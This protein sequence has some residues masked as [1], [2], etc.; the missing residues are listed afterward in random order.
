MVI[1]P[2]HPT[3]QASQNTSTSSH[4]GSEGPCCLP[5]TQLVALLPLHP[6]GWCSILLPV[7]APGPSL[8]ETG[9]PRKSEPHLVPEQ[10]PSRQPAL[11]PSFLA[12]PCSELTRYIRHS[13]YFLGEQLPLRGAPFTLALLS[14]QL[15][16]QGRS[17]HERTDPVQGRGCRYSCLRA[18]LPL[19]SENSGICMKD[20]QAQM[21]RMWNL[22]WFGAE[23]QKK[24]G[25]REGGGKGEVR[26]REG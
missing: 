12:G 25:R 9:P 16:S 22:G 11:V 26:V 19:L 5:R 4:S 1:N 3:S 15:P 24:E 7:Q 20:T 17:G 21:P 10:A 6:L 2:T 18:P 14:H 8:L 13:S 23:V